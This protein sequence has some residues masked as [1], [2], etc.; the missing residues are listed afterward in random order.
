MG[1]RSGGRRRVPGIVL[2]DCHSAERR[3]NYREVQCRRRSKHADMRVGTVAQMNGMV[4][5]TRGGITGSVGDR[6]D[7]SAVVIHGA[8]LAPSLGVVH[9]CH[10]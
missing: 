2:G 1:G 8:M 3:G 6:H 9:V 10:L 5:A 4:V 7:L